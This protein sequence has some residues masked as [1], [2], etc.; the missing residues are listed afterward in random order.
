V[1]HRRARQARR[2]G[3]LTDALAFLPLAVGFLDGI[4]LAV[5]T[6]RLHLAVRVLLAFTGFFTGYG[7]VSLVI[8]VVVVPDAEGMRD[9]AFVAVGT[10]ALAMGV[11][12]GLAAAVTHQVLRRRG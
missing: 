11:V 1:A 7:V 6:R 12:L 4:A 3:T 5:V 10:V 9:L 2:R 8:G